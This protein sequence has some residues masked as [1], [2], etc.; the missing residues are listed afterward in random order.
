MSASSVISPF[1]LR[2][3][4]IL[5]TGAS[6]GLGRQVAV[7]CSRQGARLVISGRDATR[8]QA[9]FGQL[10]GEGH[11]QLRADLTVAEER[12]HLIAAAGRLEGLVH[13]AGKQKHCL[14][15]QLSE[16]LMTDMY[17]VNFLAPLMLTQGLL[18][19][20]AITQ[21]GS[22]LFI[23]STAAHIGTPGLGP[24]SAMKSGLLGIIKCLA[25][26]QARRGIRVNGIS[27]SAIATPMWDDHQQHLEEQK[28]R[29]PLGLGT[30][31]DVSNGV[32][33]LLSDASRWVTGTSLVMDG[34]AV[35]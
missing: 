1:S 5:V 8:L 4:T 19:A 25:L 2:G 17:Q 34:G 24:Y 3:K 13:C 21:R 14:V 18:Q 6:S 12:N 10:Q 29:H 16:P 33:Y 15:R 9:T 23:L 32:I 27:P 28:A 30:P 22:I 26:E 35:I 20:N 31:D 7:R 11:V